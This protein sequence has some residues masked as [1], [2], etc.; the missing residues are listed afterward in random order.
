[1]DAPLQRTIKIGN[2]NIGLIGLDVAMNQ[3]LNRN[4]TEE[5]AADYLFDAINIKNYIPEGAEKSYKKALL[6]EFKRQRDNLEGEQKGLTIRILGPGCVSC[7]NIKIMLIEILNKLE[8]AADV[9]DI[10]ELDEVWRY[11]ITKTPA[12]IINGE[13]KSAGILPPFS[14][15]EQ[16]VREAAGL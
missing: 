1:M 16:W 9:E 2:S 3:A 14:H 13:V 12:L 8:L 7:N 6:R 4:M 11:G 5:E 15:I 10:R